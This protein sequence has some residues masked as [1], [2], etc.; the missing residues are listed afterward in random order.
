MNEGFLGTAAPRTADV[1]LLLE[2]G[3]GVGLLI[4]AVLARRRRFRLHA[5][6]QAAIV[7]L[8]LLV[9]VPLMVP[10]FHVH[11]SPKIPL[12]F[13]KAYYALATAHGALEAS[14]KS[15]DCT[16][17]CCGHERFAT[18]IPSDR[19]QTMDAR[20]ARALVAGAPVGTC[21][22]RPLVCPG[23][24]YEM[25]SWS[26]FSRLSQTAAFV[27]SRVPELEEDSCSSRQF[28]C[29]RRPNR[30]VPSPPLKNLIATSIAALRNSS[31]AVFGLLA[32]T[33]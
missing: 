27:F 20:F 6:C 31:A 26:L 13:G 14:R 2:F 28:G 22:I 10:S 21:N 12:K 16:P 15:P 32:A 19:I 17:C 11:L 5:W 24:I 3:M 29:Y 18:Q 30:E 8:N 1:A 9:I 4:G 33:I 23:L 25:N 7:L